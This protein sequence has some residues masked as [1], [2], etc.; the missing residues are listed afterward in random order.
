M[1]SIGIYNCT[2]SE[3]QHFVMQPL[4]LP[5]LRM[6]K[7]HMPI[8]TIAKCWI[9][10]GPVTFYTASVNICR[11]EVCGHVLKPWATHRELIV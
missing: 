8:F 9:F 11:L 3:L 2:G 7:F 4:I 10:A 1:L 5:I 6:I